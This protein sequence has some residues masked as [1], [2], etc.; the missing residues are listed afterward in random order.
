M[1]NK[2]QTKLRKIH[3]AYW[4]EGLIFEQSVPGERGVLVPQPEKGVDT[5]LGEQVLGKLSRKK[6]P[7]LPELNQM[8]VNRHYMR[9][10]QEVQDAVDLSINVCE[11]TCTMKY[12]PKI[13]EHM[14]RLPEINDV[15]PLQDPD[16]MQGVLEVVYKVGEFLQEVSGMDK[17]SL[18]PAAGGHAIFTAASIMRAYHRDKG[19]TQKTEIIT[20]SFSHP[21]DAAT[22]KTNGFSIITLP[23][24]KNGFPDLDALKDAISEKTAGLFITNPEDTGLYNPR[25]S[26][27]V[28][29]IHSVGGLCFYDQANANGMLGIARAKEAGFDMCHF[30][31]HKTFSAPHGSYGPGAGALGCKEFLIPYLPIPRV[32]FNGEKYILN[33][34]YPKSIGKVKMFFGNTGVLLKA[35]MWIHQLG[36]EGLKEVAKVSVLNNN[37]VEH[38]L[39]QIKGIT[40]YYGEG[41]TRLEQVRYSWEQLKEDTGVGTEGPYCRLLDFGIPDY[42]MSHPPFYVPEPMT[43]EPCESYNKDDLDEFIGALK[44]C[45]RE[46]YEEPEIYANIPPF[47]TTVRCT[48]IAVVEKPEQQ[49]MTWRLYNKN[50][51]PMLENK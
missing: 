45:A 12:S 36:A 23:P 34:D 28:D 48:E 43:I 25:I 7:F 29:L 18:Q 42:W 14:S 24:D 4:D 19:N 30:N 3:G 17:F 35:Y 31:V 10:S 46:A 11:G 21:V 22:P 2:K 8:K 13:Q 39:R 50:I 5:M 16:T 32:E 37:Y 9:L 51:R 40:M 47:N 41:S 26:E 1:D 49:G 33:S 38:F 6:A 27:Y 15:H 44:E 20:T